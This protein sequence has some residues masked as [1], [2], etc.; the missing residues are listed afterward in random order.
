[1]SESSSS[2]PKTELC[3][4]WIIA[5]PNWV[6]IAVTPSRGWFSSYTPLDVDIVCSESV[7]P[8]GLAKV[9]GIGDVLVPVKIKSRG[10]KKFVRRILHLHNA[11]HVPEA[12]CNFLG[13]EMHWMWPKLDLDAMVV[14]DRQDSN[15]P[16]LRKAHDAYSVVL[17]GPPHGTYTLFM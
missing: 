13:P 9:V 6:D 1:M 15:G 12:P 2:E 8:T 3:P 16:L 17:S 11:V 4:D 7:N 5:P 10:K 14:R